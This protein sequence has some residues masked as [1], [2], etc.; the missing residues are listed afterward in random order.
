MARLNIRPSLDEVRALSEHGNLVPIHAELPSDLDTPVSLFLRLAADDPAFL[1]ESVS[2]GEQ[3]AR[4]SFIGVHLCRAFVFRQ[5]RLVRR[6]RVN[7]QVAEH[8]ILLDQGDVLD[9][10]RRELSRYHFV[11]L[12]HLPRFCGGLVGYVGYD[13]VRQFERLPNTATDVLQLPDAVFLLCDTLVAFDHARQRLL[14]IANAFLD[15]ATTLAEAYDDAVARIKT[16]HARLSA[17]L[18]TLGLNP[19]AVCT[20]PKANK[21]QAEFEEMVRIAKRHITAGDI[22][23]VVLSRRIER[24]TTAHPFAIYRALRM[25]NPSPWMFYFNFG[26]LLDEDLKLIG[27]SP[28]MHARFE[29]GI[30]SVRPIAGTRRRGNSEREDAALAQELLNDPKE[31]AEHA[32]LVDLGRNDIGRVA[33]YG[34]VRVPELMVIE[35][36]SHV[37]H[38]V[39][40]V[41]GKVRAGL[42]AFDVLRATFPAGTLTGA[43]KVR[44]MEIIEALEG[45]RRGIYGGCIGYFSFNGQMDTCIGIRTIAM[46]GDTCYVQAGAGIVADSDPTAEFHETHNKARALMVAIDEAESA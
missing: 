10:L 16:I 4:Y 7:G 44:A 43:P 41:E 30:A 31:R 26:A 42:D 29:D 21:T 27:A 23:Q 39:S 40:L 20:P 32:M 35:H 3:V 9:A 34:S 17:P 37:M 5:D 13:V 12:P 36:Y 2:G 18:P 22:F 1:L 38:I 15:G 33:E 45:E 8:P 28:E 19:N 14:I 6:D 11:P 24:R 46:R 25:L